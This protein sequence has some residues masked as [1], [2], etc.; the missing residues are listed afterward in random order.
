MFV[1]PLTSA[2]CSLC[3]H[4]GSA[5]SLRTAASWIREFV[6]SHPGYK[7]DSVVSQEVN[8]DLMIAIDEM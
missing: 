2:D 1:R 4:R 8:Y 5:G 3:R 7:F 6:R